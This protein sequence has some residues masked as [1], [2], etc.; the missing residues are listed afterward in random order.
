MTSHI[1]RAKR[2][3]AAFP[4]R[5]APT[6]TPTADTVETAAAAYDDDDAS[7]AAQ[8]ALVADPGLLAALGPLTPSEVRQLLGPLPSRAIEGLILGLYDRIATDMRLLGTARIESALIVARRA[9]HEAAIAFKL[10][11][12]VA[13]LELGASWLTSAG[14]G[15]ES[16]RRLAARTPIEAD[17]LSVRS[18]YAMHRPTF[19]DLRVRLAASPL[20]TP[21]AMPT[22]R[23]AA[24]AAAAISSA[25][26]SS[27]V[28]SAVGGRPWGPMA[29]LPPSRLGSRAAARILIE[30]LRALGLNTSSLGAG[31]ILLASIYDLFGRTDDTTVPPAPRATTP[32]T[33]RPV[34]AHDVSKTLRLVDIG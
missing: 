6:T 2:H 18:L 5:L 33:A 30:C 23:E 28:R 9:S 12:M 11:R 3:L 4:L 32:P 26:C 34:T 29:V 10:G 1:D 16:V 31:L 8:R 20:W 17:I 22:L 19:A 7:M 13:R 14:L 24:L 25:P 15:P 21:N 27:L